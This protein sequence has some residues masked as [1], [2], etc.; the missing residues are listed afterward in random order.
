MIDIFLFGFT[1]SA[2]L[3]YTLLNFIIDFHDF[4]RFNISEFK[5]KIHIFLFDIL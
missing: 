3:D 2:V 4:C 5:V 1:S